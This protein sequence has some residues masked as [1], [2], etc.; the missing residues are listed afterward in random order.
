M[1]SIRRAKIQTVY[2][3]VNLSTSAR[4]KVPGQGKQECLGNPIKFFPNVRKKGSISEKIQQLFFQCHFEFP[5]KAVNQ[6]CSCTA[7]F[8]VKTAPKALIQQKAKAFKNPNLI[9]AKRK[10]QRETMTEVFMVA[11]EKSD[12]LREL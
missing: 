10:I 8:S 3:S 7:T 1:V 12:G 2:V 5:A 4:E 6:R 9:C 11:L